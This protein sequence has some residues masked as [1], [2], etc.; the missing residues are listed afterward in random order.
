MRKYGRTDANQADIVKALRKAG[1]S[2]LILSDVG[3]GCP[4]LLV[5]RGGNNF[6][7]ECKDPSKSPSERCLTADQ[8]VFFQDWRG[9]GPMVVETPKEALF[10]CGAISAEVYRGMCADRQR[11][12]KTRAGRKGAATSRKAPGTLKSELRQV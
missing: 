8:R 7:L 11:A 1:C 9:S 3:G 10:L 5:G 4:D 2:V 6:L 12:A